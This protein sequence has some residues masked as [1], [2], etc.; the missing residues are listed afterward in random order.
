GSISAA[1]LRS[2]ATSASRNDP[3]SSTSTTA[4]TGRGSVGASAKAIP[5]E[6]VTS[7]T[8]GTV[9]TST[10]PTAAAKPAILTSCTPVDRLADRVG[11]GATTSRH[12]RVHRD[13]SPHGPI[14]PGR[15][16]PDARPD[17]GRWPIGV[18]ADTVPGKVITS[19]AHHSD[20]GDGAGPD[21]DDPFGWS[22]TP[23]I[24]CSPSLLRW[25]IFSRSREGAA[26]RTVARTA[27]GGL[28]SSITP[29]SWS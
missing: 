13:E 28:L 22:A 21:N 3:D 14:P 11:K 19:L 2:A 1:A 20:S 17:R 26:M 23:W 16:Q 25:F 10:V 29:R 15:R 5:G 7:R 4:R 9:S 12:R 8:A 24:R 6:T 27:A 18:R